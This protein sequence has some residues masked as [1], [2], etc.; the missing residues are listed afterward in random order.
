MARLVSARARAGRRRSP[1]TLIRN[2]ARSRFG[3]PG[4]RLGLA[5]PG[6]RCLAPPARLAAAAAESQRIHSPSSQCGPGGARR[7]FVTGTVLPHR[8]ERRPAGAGLPLRSTGLGA[9]AVLA[10]RRR[11]AAAA[12]AQRRR[13]AARH[14][15]RR[16]GTG[17][18]VERAVR[19]A[20]GRTAG[21][22][23]ARRADDG[24][25]PHHRDDPD[26]RA[27]RADGTARPP[28]RP[29]GAGGG[30]A[31][32]S[33]SAPRFAVRSARSTAPCSTSRCRRRTGCQSL[34]RWTSCAPS[35]PLREAT[36]MVSGGPRRGRRAQRYTACV[37]AVPFR[38]P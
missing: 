2:G 34:C 31:C 21:Q 27:H 25:R 8:G 36:S 7:G 19:S 17:V 26:D 3:A 35:R 14:P 10:P 12:T 37:P 4:R 11:R 5:L 20:G 15:R 18:D 24:D 6:A 32:L 16:P 13:A 30:G 29:Q 38:A 9:P 28:R 23:L 22:R 1:T 33:R